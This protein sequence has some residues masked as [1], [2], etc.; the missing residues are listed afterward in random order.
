[1]DGWMDGWMDIT[2]FGVYYRVS[3]S[4]PPTPHLPEWDLVL[5]LRLQYEP[6]QPH[7]ALHL[8]QYST[9]QHTVE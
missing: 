8:L 9:A 4:L 2:A 3:S 6:L 1:M 7:I 5:L